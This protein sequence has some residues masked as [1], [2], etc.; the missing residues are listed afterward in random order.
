MTEKTDY[1]KII[2]DNTPIIDQVMDLF[3][4]EGLSSVT[5]SILLMHMLAQCLAI[6]CFEEEKNVE[7][8]VNRASHLIQL[9]AQLADVVIRKH[10]K[11]EP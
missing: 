6:M 10:G 1:F 3:E 5:G 9:M 7:E 11:M 8:E 2:K 4:H